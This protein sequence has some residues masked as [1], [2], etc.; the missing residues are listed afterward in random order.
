M[1]LQHETRATTFL[2]GEGTF[3]C[4]WTVSRRIREPQCE[5]RSSSTV[6]SVTF[7]SGLAEPRPPNLRTAHHVASDAKTIIHHTT[8]ETDSSDD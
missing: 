1:W 4:R 8:C 2:Y 3:F 7:R 5:H 6:A